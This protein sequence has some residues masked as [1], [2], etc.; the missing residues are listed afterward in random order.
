MQFGEAH[1]EKTTEFELE[2]NPKP[3][4]T[5]QMLFIKVVPDGQP[6]QAW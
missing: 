1:F 5:W 2:T 4:F 6:T 3:V